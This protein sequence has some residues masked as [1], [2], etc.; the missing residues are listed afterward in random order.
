M[1]QAPSPCRLRHVHRL[2]LRGHPF[3]LPSPSES[4][5][6]LSPKERPSPLSSDG[7]EREGGALVHGHGTTEAVGKVD[8]DVATT[9]SLHDVD[10]RRCK[11]Q[12]RGGI[13]C[14]GGCVVPSVEAK[15]CKEDASHRRIEHAHVARFW[16]HPR[17]SVGSC[18]FEG[19]RIAPINSRSV[20]A[21]FQGT[22]PCSLPQRNA[23]SA[24]VGESSRRGAKLSST[25]I[26]RGDV[27]APPERANHT[28][29][30]S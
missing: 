11:S 24:E 2:C 17:T 28:N 25:T 18:Q 16:M 14:N 12:K 6:N 13:G 29:H 8:V 21:G 27:S 19:R 15:A 10:G 7:F 1:A 20:E 30:R 3:R 4:I 26:P 22:D 23:S 9:G 5:G